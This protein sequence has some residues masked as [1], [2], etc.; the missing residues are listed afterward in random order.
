MSRVIRRKTGKNESLF[1]TRMVL[2]KVMHRMEEIGTQDI[3]MLH[4]KILKLYNKI[5]H[6]YV[7]SD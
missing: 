6:L 1:Q 5:G 3:R 7:H 4:L 2:C